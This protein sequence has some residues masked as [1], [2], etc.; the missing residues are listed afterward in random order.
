MSGGIFRGEMS[1][2]FGELFRV[3]GIFH[4]E[5]VR[6][7]SERFVGSGCP[8]PMQDYKSLRVAV[9]IW[10]TLVNTQTAFDRLY[11]KLSQLS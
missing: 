3:R 7:I 2:G 4:G 1:R 9:T 5:N 8:H 10:A 6:G 11:Y